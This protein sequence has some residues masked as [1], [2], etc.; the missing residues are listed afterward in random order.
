MTSKERQRRLRQV[1]EAVSNLSDEKAEVRVLLNEGVL[2]PA[3]AQKLFH[4]ITESLFE[5]QRQL[6]Y[7]MK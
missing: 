4:R 5:Q 1:E 7:L 6:E 3:Q 2:T